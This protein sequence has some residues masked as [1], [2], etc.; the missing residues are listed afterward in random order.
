MCSYFF[1]ALF[2]NRRGLSVLVDCGV[3]TFRDFQ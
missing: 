2:A 1:L 3:F